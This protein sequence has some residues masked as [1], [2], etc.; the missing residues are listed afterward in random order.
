M[1]SVAIGTTSKLPSITVET[2]GGTDTYCTLFN[3][4]QESLATDDDSGT[5]L[6][7]RIEATEDAGEYFIEVRGYSGSTTGRYELSVGASD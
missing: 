2:K 6:N 3:D 7:C 4:D 1:R 5:N